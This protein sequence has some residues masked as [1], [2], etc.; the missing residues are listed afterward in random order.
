[1]A[2][3]ERQCC[4]RLIER[5]IQAFQCTACQ[6]QSSLQ[7]SVVIWLSFRVRPGRQLP[8]LPQVCS[9]ACGIRK[10]SLVAQDLPGGLAL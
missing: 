7:A 8:V 9:A 1:M 4:H 3:L 2:F 6:F 10:Q 5:H